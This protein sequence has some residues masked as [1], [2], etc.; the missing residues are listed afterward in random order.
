MVKGGEDMKTMDEG[1][2]KTVDELFLILPFGYIFSGLITPMDEASP[3]CSDWPAAYACV[4][5]MPR[6]RSRATRNDEGE[7]MKGSGIR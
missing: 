1:E 4:R 7:R 5:V 2:R 3:P 6:I